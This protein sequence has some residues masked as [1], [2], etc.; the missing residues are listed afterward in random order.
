MICYSYY[1]HIPVFSWSDAVLDW[2]SSGMCIWRPGLMIS[3]E[4]KA[5]RMMIRRTFA[6]LIGLFI[7]TWSASCDMEFCYLGI[8]QVNIP[9]IATWH[10]LGMEFRSFAVDAT[11]NE[12]I[13]LGYAL[14]LVAVILS[15][16]SKYGLGVEFEL[17]GINLRSIL[18]ITL[19]HLF[20]NQGFKPF[21]RSQF[22]LF[23]SLTW[24]PSISLVRSKMIEVILR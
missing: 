5:S 19:N 21:S 1:L 8:G 12:W 4:R 17:P 24:S 20:L 9:F 3:A 2:H 10:C 7:S 22:L 6:A 16:I 14:A 18:S 13:R 11:W 23:L 15:V